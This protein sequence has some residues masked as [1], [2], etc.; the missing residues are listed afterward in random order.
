VGLCTLAL[1]E[2]TGSRLLLSDR[3]GHGRVTT[4]HWVVAAMR[5]YAPGGLDDAPTHT[6]TDAAGWIDATAHVRVSKFQPC[7][8]ALIEGELVARELMD[9]NDAAATLRAW[10]GQCPPSIFRRAQDT[11]Q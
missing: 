1:S 5:V 2:R 4:Q 9:L 3:R 10:R 11:S 7:L 6:W 8:P